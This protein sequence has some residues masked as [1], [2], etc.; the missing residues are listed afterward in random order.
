MS[1]SGNKS[2]RQSPSHEHCKVTAAQSLAR[3]DLLQLNPIPQVYEVWYRYFSGEPAV[4][5]ALDTLG[6][7]VTDD[8]CLDL[9]AQLT[10][11]DKQ[12]EKL[13]KIGHQVHSSTA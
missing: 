12:K 13:S 3:S 7:N 1:G 8:D 2:K 10:G 6:D 4:I 11:D 5:K 9:Y